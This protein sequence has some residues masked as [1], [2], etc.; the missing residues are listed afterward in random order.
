MSIS[1]VSIVATSRDDKYGD[2]Q[3][4]RYFFSQDWSNVERIYYTVDSVLKQFSARGI[5]AEYV[6]VDWAPIDGNYLYKNERLKSLLSDPRVKNIIVDQSACEKKG[7]I[8]TAYYEYFAKN[9]GIRQ[10]TGDFLLVTNP[11][12]FFQNVLVDEMC[13]AMEDPASDKSYY[14][15]EY[16]EDISAIEDHTEALEFMSE[17]Y[18]NQQGQ[19]KLPWH[20]SI[21]FEERLSKCPQDNFTF[22]A[23]ARGW[24][25]RPISQTEYHIMEAKVGSSAAGDFLFIKKSLLINT[26]EGY[27]ESTRDRYNPGWPNY[28]D[29]E[30]IHKLY[31]ASIL[32]V[33]LTGAVQSYDHGKGQLHGVNNL[34]CYTNT[35]DWGMVEYRQKKINDNTFMILGD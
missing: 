20:D 6:L 22:I 14:R 7:L 31:N 10:S 21:P 15:P 35:D 30:I 33:L 5:D 19:Y 28:Q 17:N 3:A 25:F 26:G 12:N 8:P 29:G 18:G 9:V 27:D 11:D 1:K 34:G 13:S 23:H 16:R 4:T 24:T 2:D 32:P